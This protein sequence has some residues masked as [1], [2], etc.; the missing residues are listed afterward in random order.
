MRRV[1][2]WLRGNVQNVFLVI[3]LL[4]LVVCGVDRDDTSDIQAVASGVQ[5]R[6]SHMENRMLQFVSQAFETAPEQWLFMDNLPRD[7]VI[8]KYVD[9]TLQSWVNSFPLFN[10]NLNSINYNRL[11]RTQT[12]FS[13]LLSEV[14]E[15]PSYLNIGS[16]WYLVRSFSKGNV[17]LLCGLA[18]KGESNQ[19][20]LFSGV[21]PKLSLSS[22]FTILPLPFSEGVHVRSLQGNPVFSV[23]YSQDVADTE[24][25]THSSLKWVTLMFCCMT[26][27][28]LFLKRRTF[29]SFSITAL[30]LMASLFLAFSWAKASAGVSSGIFSPAVYADTNLF[31]S[32]GELLLHN[33]ALF[34]L[35]LSLFLM[36]R[37]FMLWFCKQRP[38]ARVLYGGVFAVFGLMLLAYIHISLKSVIFNSNIVLEVFKLDELSVYSFL[39][40]VSAIMLFMAFLFYLQLLSPVLMKSK[41]TIF[42]WK[43]LLKYSLVVAMYMMAVFSLYGRTR[44]MDRISVWMN[45]LSVK[46]DLG[47]ELLLR[48]VEDGIA[49]DMVINEL[50]LGDY[51]TQMIA[52]RL[53]EYY[54]GRLFTSYDIKV[55]QGEL[56]AGSAGTYFRSLL[57]NSSPLH[58]NSHFYYVNDHTGKMRYLGLFIYIGKDNSLKRLYVELDSKLMKPQR[59]YS[60]IFPDNYGGGYNIPMAYSYAKYVSGTLVFYRGS[61]NF[62]VSVSRDYVQSFPEGISRVFIRRSEVF[63]NRLSDE[64]MILIARPRRTVI[65]YLIS[66]SYMSFLT[67]MCMFLILLWK[68]AKKDTVM[69]SKSFRAR[70]MGLLIITVT[71]TFALLTV[72]TVIFFVN[73]DVKVRNEILNDKLQSI[74]SMMQDVSRRAGGIDDLLSFDVR[75]LLENIAGNTLT[76]INLYDTGGHLR[77]STRSDIQ[78]GA[79]ASSKM[80]PDAFYNIVHL[81]RKTFVN[82]ENISGKPI[83]SLYAPVINGEGKLIA[84]LNMPYYEQTTD[85]RKDIFSTSAAIINIFLLLVVAVIAIGA[86]ITKALFR[87]L[88]DLY[89]RMGDTDIFN[90]SRRIE[91]DNNDE[92]SYIVGA[93]NRMLDNLQDSSRRLATIEREQAWKEMASQIAHDI[94][95]PLTPMRLNIQH[96]LRM[97]HNADPNLDLKMERIC[98]SLL[99]QID[100][101]TDTVTEFSSVAKLNVEQ[102]QVLDLTEILNEQRVFFEGYECVNIH[103][104]VAGEMI[105]EKYYVL[106]PK[107]QMTRVFYN[108]LTNAVQ[109]LTP[110][111]KASGVKGD[112]VVTLSKYTAAEDSD[113]GTPG[114]RYVRVD[115]EDNGPGVPAENMPKLFT[116]KFTTKSTGTGLGLVICKNVVEMIDGTVKYYTSEEF[117]G[118][119]F[120]VMIPEYS[121]FISVSGKSV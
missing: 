78:Y 56:L 72:T 2:E 34:I 66:Y 49:Q 64:D 111:Y 16:N 30:A 89:E 19:A 7:M 47:T 85:F 8:Y 28:A 99:E 46:R 6:L 33:L 101:M 115:I 103:F 40:F 70:I 74:H 25:P 24:T 4:L 53:S 114:D 45:R 88:S 44:E 13:P 93:Y 118:A 48:N 116:P 1:L 12:Y 41:F 106:G 73:R 17:K 71:G 91:Y 107:S 15:V 38:F 117:G 81:K 50:V 62:P 36:R 5:K 37:R 42:N 86:A 96:L 26:L 63:V 87:P 121:E 51:P 18:I 98:N 3:S 20:S 59:G 27:Y 14:S 39:V 55:T 9:D 110:A 54:L 105:D 43:F 60:G 120:R 57:A 112:I 32:L 52:D 75:M 108:L 104:R 97:K 11:S 69:K 94:K 67:I 29:A 21:N 61:Y 31:S 90:S 113:F 76:D 84:I 35:A 22:K 65:P 58:A 109:A 100:V 119:D 95:N 80:D 92:I 68:P 23:A 79:M 82:Q 83:Y 102:N 10:D 77:Q